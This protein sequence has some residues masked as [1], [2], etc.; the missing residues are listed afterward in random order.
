MIKSSIHF[1]SLAAC[2]AAAGFAE[3]FGH[4]LARRDFETQNGAETPA[5]VEGDDVT[6]RFREARQRRAQGERIKME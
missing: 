3:A 2:T 6:E 4:V 5:A 1:Y